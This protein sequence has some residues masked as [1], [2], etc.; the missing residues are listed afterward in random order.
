MRH[1]DALEVVLREL[2]PILRSRRARAAYLIGSRARGTA[3]AS[4]DIDLVIVAESERSAVERFKDYLPAIVA[5]PVG[6]DLLLYTP[7]EFDRMV[8][9]ERPFLVHALE[10]AKLVY[11]G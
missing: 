1:M 5:S 4:S 11:E 2:R 7:D 8:T 9:E 6:V 10:G 3:H